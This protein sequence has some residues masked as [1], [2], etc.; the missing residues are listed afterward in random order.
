MRAA[1]PNA[2]SVRK[3][4]PEELSGMSELHP[5]QRSA[6]ENSFSRTKLSWSNR[7]RDETDFGIRARRS[8]SNQAAIC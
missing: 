2:R 4:G 1:Q 8:S 5:F 3:T 6:K 7:S